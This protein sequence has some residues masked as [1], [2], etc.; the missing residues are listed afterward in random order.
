MRNK[1]LSIMLG[2]VLTASALCG[3]GSEANSVQVESNVGDTVIADDET[4]TSST[5][6][7]E[8]LP[9][10]I[11]EGIVKATPEM[12]TDVDLSKHKTVNITLIGDTP[13]A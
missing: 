2:V 8:G 12:Y 1:V 13:T 7:L 5:V 4:A 3:C 6:S 10:A 9:E 11:G